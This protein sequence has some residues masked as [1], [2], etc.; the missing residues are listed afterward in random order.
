V[1]DPTRDPEFERLYRAEFPRLVR[2][3]ASG[4][5]AA[6]A[7]DAVQEAFLK[8]GARWGRVSTLDQPAAWIRRVALNHLYNDRRNEKRRGEILASLRPVAVRDNSDLDAALAMLSPQRRLV[9]A[10]FYGVGY[11]IMEIAELLDLTEGTV[12]RYL[13]EARAQLKEAILEDQHE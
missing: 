9:V 11:P 12:K 2:A 13:H 8:A 1:T 4:F 6:S 3:F 10:L 5:G 7:A